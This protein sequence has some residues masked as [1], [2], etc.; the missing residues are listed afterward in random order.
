MNIYP[1]IKTIHFIENSRDKGYQACN[2]VALEVKGNTLTIEWL[3][4][5]SK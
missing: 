3:A 2:G 4:E 5:E 1:N